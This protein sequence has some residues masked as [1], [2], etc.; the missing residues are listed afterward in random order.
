MTFIRSKATG[1]TSSTDPSRSHY[2]TSV[3]GRLKPTHR[4]CTQVSRRFLTLVIAYMTAV[5]PVTARARRST[6]ARSSSNRWPA[7][8][9][10]AT[11][12]PEKLCWTRHVGHRE[13]GLEEEIVR[14][15][16]GVDNPEAQQHLGI[17]TRTTRWLLEELIALDIIG[18][19]RRLLADDSHQGHRGCVHQLLNRLRSPRQQ[20]A[21]VHVWMWFCATF[22]AQQAGRL[23]ALDDQ[24]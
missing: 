9:D 3:G 23:Q 16:L 22:A 10:C 18:E 14:V 24:S 19:R 21:H 8:R 7:L 2:I 20:V 6:A 4:S 12:R 1:H 15:R 17:G 11:A 13:E 5:S